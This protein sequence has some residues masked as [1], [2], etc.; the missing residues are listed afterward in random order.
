MASFKIDCSDLIN[1]IRLYANSVV[2]SVATHIRDE[3]TETA[4]Y[5]LEKFYSDYT[6]KVYKRHYDI[7]NFI[8]THNRYQVNSFKKYYVHANR[9]IYKVGVL[10]STDA[11]SKQYKKPM[12]DVYNGTVDE[13]FYSVYHGYHGLPLPKTPKMNPDP[14]TII[15]DKQRDILSHGQNY[16]DL[17]KNKYIDILNK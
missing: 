9:G 12:I 2:K 17:Y 15:Y 8:N 10:L 14:L 3:I 4:A 11:D 7:H 1:R 13:V 16:I 5:A 6:P